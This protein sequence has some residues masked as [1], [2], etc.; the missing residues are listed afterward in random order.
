MRIVKPHHPQRFTI[1]LDCVGLIEQ[2]SDPQAFEFRYH[3]LHIMI[4]QDT[5][6]TMTG[7]D[8]GENPLHVRIDVIA[9]S[10]HGKAVVTR[11]HT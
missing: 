10:S 7:V 6:Y 3:L 9:W 5:D 4:P 1:C 2:H 8:T 11:E